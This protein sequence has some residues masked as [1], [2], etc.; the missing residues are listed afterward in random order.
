MSKK[1]TK[2]VFV[3]EEDSDGNLYA[4]FRYKGN[5]LS[6]LLGWHDWWDVTIIRTDYDLKG[7]ILSST[8]L[9]DVMTAI[10][11][12]LKWIRDTYH[13]KNLI[14][15]TYVIDETGSKLIKEE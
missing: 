4:K 12:K 11:K 10:E 1:Y 8:K 15:E 9:E 2:C 13:R 5:W 14:T 6:E 7:D 3:I